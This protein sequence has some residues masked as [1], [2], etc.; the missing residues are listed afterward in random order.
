MDLPRSSTI[1]SKAEEIILLD[2]LS[3]LDPEMCGAVVCCGV[4]FTGGC[5]IHDP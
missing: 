3:L 4:G 5:S 1:T 2:A